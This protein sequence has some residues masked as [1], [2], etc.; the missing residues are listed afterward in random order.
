MNGRGGHHGHLIERVGLHAGIDELVREQGIGA[1]REGRLDLDGAGCRVHLVVEREQGAGGK[2]VFLVPIEGGHGHGA[3]RHRLMDLTEIVFGHGIDYG[4]RAELRDDRDAGRGGR[5][6]IVAR[7]D[8]AQA[9]HAID[10]RGYRAITDLH[11]KILDVA[12]VGLHC[13][14]V[15][16]HGRDLGV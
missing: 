15:F 16:L 10:R 7:I 5:R 2:Q 8:E 14:F 12:G 13:A 4:G 6:D 3:A 1:G 11:L 9:D